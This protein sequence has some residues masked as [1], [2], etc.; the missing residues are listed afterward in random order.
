MQKSYTIRYEIES[1][2]YCYLQPTHACMHSSWLHSTLLLTKNNEPQ[3]LYFQLCNTNY[4][5][6]VL[7][8]S[9]AVNEDHIPTHVACTFCRNSPS[10]F[11]KR[12]WPPIYR[13]D[14]SS[15]NPRWKTYISFSLLGVGEEFSTCW[16]LYKAF[17][18]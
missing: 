8:D 7:W 17:L 15:I 2:N 1:I 13:L 12:L 10:V 18:M 3:L 6:D 16:K 11:L 4:F 14:P 9:L 5:N